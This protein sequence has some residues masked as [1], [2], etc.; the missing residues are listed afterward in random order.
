MGIGALSQ[1]RN[2]LGM[3]LA[4]HLQLTPKVRMSGATTLLPPNMSSWCEEG[5]FYIFA[6]HKSL[7]KLK[8]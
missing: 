2:S 6:L 3:K 5:T 1:K 4:S 7:Q 8:Y